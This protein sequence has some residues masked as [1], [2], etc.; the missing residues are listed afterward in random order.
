MCVTATAISFS[1]LTLLMWSLLSA[2]VGFLKTQF[3]IQA[4]FIT[5]EV[6]KHRHLQNIQSLSTFPPIY[7]LLGAVAKSIEHMPHVLEIVGS[8]RGS[9]KP[10]PDKI[11]TCSFLARCLAFLG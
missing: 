5:V 3:H 4:F 1:V 2:G 7:S 11:D 8:N 6:N 10:M 9:V